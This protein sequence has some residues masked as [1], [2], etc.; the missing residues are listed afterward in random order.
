MIPYHNI[1]KEIITIGPIS[2]LWYSMMYVLGYVIGFFIF[3]RRRQQGL[4]NVSKD[5]LEN[6]PTYLIIGM[7][8]GARI[9][10]VF[11][12][13]WDFY[14]QNLSEI[15]NIQN[16]G[17]S[18]HGAMI[19]M[20]LACMLF[21]RRH[22]VPTYM[23]LDTM[24]I[25]GGPGLF[26]GRIGNFINGE[27]YGR[28]TDVP[29][30]MVFPDDPTGLARHPSQLYQGLTEGLLLWGILIFYQRYLIKNNKYRNG[31]IGSSFVIGYGVFRFFVEYTREADAQ[32]GYF[33]NGQLSM[34][35]ILC[36]IMIVAGFMLR[37][38][39]GKHNDVFKVKPLKN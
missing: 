9:F 35:Q 20:I 37:A 29:W 26:L 25:A 1:P 17:L 15:I 30:A 21:S 3:K 4:F 7:L 23:T 39:S 2:I 5:A 28:A 32:L 16:G 8:L 12:Y 19:G 10:Y 13:N 34:G 11:I 36:L 18:F 31:L 38:H 6:F 27:L 33:M 22:N 14:S 24:A